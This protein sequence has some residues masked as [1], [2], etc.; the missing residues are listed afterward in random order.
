MTSIRRLISWAGV[1]VQ[2]GCAAPPPP[3]DPIVIDG[4][5]TLAPLTEAI[6]ADFQ[7]THRH[8]PLKLA[9]VGTAEGFAHFCRGELDILDASR[10]VSVSEQAA[11]ASANVTFIELPVAQDAVTVIV[12]ARNTWASSMSVSELRR[13]WE[14]AAETKIT[15]WNQIRSDWPDRPIKLFGPGAESGTF[16]FFTEAVTGT[17]DSSRKDYTASGNDLVI[18]DGVGGDV[19]ALGYVGYGYF[20]RNRESLKALA[21]DDEDDSVGRGPIEP[22][23]LNV[24]RGVYRP[25]ARP[26]FI[27]VNQARLSRPEVKTLVD[28][29]VRRASELAIGA[30]A[31]P[32][33]GTSYALVSERLAKGMTGTMFKTA[34]DRTRG[35][36]L[37]LHQ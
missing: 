2:V 32:L 13:L 34:E 35:I 6:V 37:L 8:V 25:F 12:N 29:Y 33:I 14:P 15:R 18:V 16:D 5:S 26:L 20:D 28:T 19:E 31:V 22:S 21:L 24:G 7:K 30:G 11:C 17:V 9:S 4:S 3:T 10:P 36:D 27:Y 1:L 23:P